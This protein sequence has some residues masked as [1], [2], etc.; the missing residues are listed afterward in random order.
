[1]IPVHILNYSNFR[2]RVPYIE[3]VHLIFGCG[4]STAG[5]TSSVYIVCDFALDTNRVRDLTQAASGHFTRL[6]RRV[7]LLGSVA[8]RGRLQVG[9]C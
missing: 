6:S 2:W 9:K 7:L 4:S 1:M 3:L 8:S 5:R